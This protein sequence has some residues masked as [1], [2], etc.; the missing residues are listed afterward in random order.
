M[1]G[2]F[3]LG[4]VSAPVGEDVWEA[5]KRNQEKKEPQPSPAGDPIPHYPSKAR[6]VVKPF[7]SPRDG[8]RGRWVGDNGRTNPKNLS[9]AGLRHAAVSKKTSEPLGRNCR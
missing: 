3:F 5:Q 9:V 4:L 2:S 8:P 7:L 6:S 1:G